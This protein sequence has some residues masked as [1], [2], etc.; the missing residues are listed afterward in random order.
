MKLVIDHSSLSFSL[1]SLHQFMSLD[2]T[3]DDH[4]SSL[5]RSVYWCSP[6][7]PLD[8]SIAFVKFNGD[9]IGG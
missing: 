6:P 7:H 3:S 5:S 1:T 8:N 2:R 9:E 4:L